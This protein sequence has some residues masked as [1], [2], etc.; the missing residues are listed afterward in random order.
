MD[1]LTKKFYAL[2]K[3]TNILIIA[4][5]DFSHYTSEKRAQLHDLKSYYTL[6]H[7][8]NWK[9]YQSIEVD[10]PTCLFVVN[11]WAKKQ[12]QYPELMV[13]DSNSSIKHKDMGNENTS[14]EFII[15]T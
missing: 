3:N 2:Q 11:T 8:S 1:K 10:C 12:Q 6:L 14:R 15:Y 5:V 13:R 9:E 4:S 7:S